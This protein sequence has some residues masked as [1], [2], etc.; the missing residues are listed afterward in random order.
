MTLFQTPH[1]SLGTRLIAVVLA[2]TTCAFMVVAGFTHWRLDQ[3]LAEQTA[4]LTAL[5][6]AKLSERLEGE[7]R[8]G[9]FRLETTFNEFS[10]GIASLAARENIAKA[11]TAND[12]PRLR[13]ALTQARAGAV[14]NGLIV[15]DEKMRVV[16]AETE[17]SNIIAINKALSAHPAAAKFDALIK[18][19]SRSSPTHVKEFVAQ[20][21]TLFQALGGRGDFV[22]FFLA[23]HPVFDDFGEVVAVLIATRRLMAAEPTLIGLN[24]IIGA[25][26]AIA[27]GQKIMSYAGLRDTELP[28]SITDAIASQR[29]ANGNFYYRCGQFGPGV[30]LCAFRPETDLSSQRDELVRISKSQNQALSFSLI[31]I[32]IGCLVVL[33]IALALVMRQFTRPLTQIATSIGRVAA[34]ETQT[35]IVG[36]QRYD[37]IGQIARAVDVFKQSVT[38]ADRLRHEKTKE[39]QRAEKERRLVMQGLADDFR[40]TV[41]A[42]LDSVS[43][44]AADLEATANAMNKSSERTREQSTVVA[45][46]SEASASNIRKVA[47]TTEALSESVALISNEV[48][49]AREVAIEAVEQAKDA[50]AQLQNLSHAA[51]KVGDIVKIITNVTAQTN[52]LALNATIEAARAGEAGR[53]FAVVAGEV[54]EL[55]SQTSRAAEGIAGQ[56]AEM[57]AVT[58]ASAG[59]IRTILN[60]I[61][62]ISEISEQITEAT[63]QQ[64]VSTHDIAVSAQQS[65]AASVEVSANFNDATRSIIETGKVASQVLSSANLMTQQSTNLRLQVARFLEKVKA[66]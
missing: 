43:H 35:E 55:A 4:E 63:R 38:E 29:F 19:N 61:A 23:A 26:I 15:L 22:P 48:Q 34:G 49:R 33:G 62:M 11:I 5:T 50:D 3:N 14:A 1:K 37:E 39:S 45:Q 65:A 28:L 17:D 47:Q 41:G 46:A 58:D 44:A 8:L 13:Q 66:A 52:L 18:N 54:K 51:Q 25:G 12:H 10:S 31:Q 9:L 7:V 40:A 56:I 60:T 42:V 30:N 57:Q 2:I 6:K 16:V 20:D 36:L 24:R 53:G 32:A 21:A 59:S 27:H 64:T